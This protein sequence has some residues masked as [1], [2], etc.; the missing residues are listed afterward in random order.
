M[1]QGRAA[2]KHFILDFFCFQ[3]ELGLKMEMFQIA[4]F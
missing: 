3:K 2:D 4:I 1:L